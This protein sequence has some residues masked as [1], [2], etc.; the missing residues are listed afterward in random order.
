MNGKE[1]N[2]TKNISNSIKPNWIVSNYSVKIFYKNIFL[3]YFESEIPFWKE[4][5]EP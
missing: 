4:F 2:K 5:W 3:R 1:H